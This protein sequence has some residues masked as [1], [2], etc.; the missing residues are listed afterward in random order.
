MSNQ[1]SS[2]SNQQDQIP[3]LSQLAELDKQKENK[4]IFDTFE[5]VQ[6]Y[7]SLICKRYL[8]GPIKDDDQGVDALTKVAC[9]VFVLEGYYLEA[10][11]FIKNKISEAEKKR[12][13]A[14]KELAGKLRPLVDA[15]QIATDISDETK[16]KL[17]EAHEHFSKNHPEG[18]TT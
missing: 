12:I 17:I 6:N 9:A 14:E 16:Q 1:N 10:N 11:N 18:S 5:D 2:S 3:T 8:G 7:L 4:K 15:A 13:E